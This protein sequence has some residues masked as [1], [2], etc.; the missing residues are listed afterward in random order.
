LTAFLDSKET[1]PDAYLH[2]AR[3]AFKV[4]QAIKEDSS[5]GTQ[6]AGS[7][8]DVAGETPAQK[9]YRLAKKPNA[10]PAA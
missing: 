9:F 3:F 8:D 6:G 2:F 5:A 4:G 7:G 1:G 10:K